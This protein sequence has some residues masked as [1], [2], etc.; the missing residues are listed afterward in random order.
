[1]QT[2]VSSLMEQLILSKALICILACNKHEGGNL[3]CLFVF[4]LFAEVVQKCLMVCE[5]IMLI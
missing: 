1:M 4:C 5:Q 3:S 2:K